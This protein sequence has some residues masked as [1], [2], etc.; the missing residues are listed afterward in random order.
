MT[1]PFHGRQAGFGAIMAIVIL[2]ILATLAAAI[3]RF[4]STQQLTSAQDIQSAK[5]SAA[6]RSGNDWGLYQALKGT[7][8]ACSGL[9][10][11]LDLR[12]ETGFWVTVSC[13][14]TLYNEGESSPGV[15]TT[16]RVFTIESTACISSAGCPDATAASSPLYVERKRQVIATN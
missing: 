8:S 12:T 9:T 16:I 15:A 4:G 10:Q 6:A 14:S 13:N 5:A 2:V 1:V 7:W 11:Q 3:V